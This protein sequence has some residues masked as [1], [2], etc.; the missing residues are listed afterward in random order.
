[1]I[2]RL[3]TPVMAQLAELF[4]GIHLTVLLVCGY[5][6]FLLGIAIGLELLARTSH[7][8]SHRFRTMGFT[9]HRQLDIWECSQGEHLRPFELDRRLR[10]IR[11]RAHPH[12]CN[13]CSIK[14][15][16]TDSDRGREIVRFLDPWPRS[17][18]GRFHRGLSAVLGLLAG[19]MVV[20]ATVFHHRPQ[21]LVLLGAVLAAV[22]SVTLRLVAVLLAS[23]ANFPTT[24][25]AEQLVSRVR[26][27]K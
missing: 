3:E 27:R 11:Y 17:E 4:T 9:Y 19:V 18:I 23:P 1:V 21:E 16:C 13:H 5:A 14:Q 12:A 7:R 22:I 15:A 2:N 25:T 8:R 10:L 26:D 24:H 20:I 6:I